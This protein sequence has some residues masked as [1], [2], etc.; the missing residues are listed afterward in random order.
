MMRKQTLCNLGI[1]LR[2][3]YSSYGRYLILNV[4]LQ[5]QYDVTD[6]LTMRMITARYCTTGNYFVT[7]TRVSMHP[8]IIERVNQ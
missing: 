5:N 6:L 2:E 7:N 8:E 1:V 4:S 3:P